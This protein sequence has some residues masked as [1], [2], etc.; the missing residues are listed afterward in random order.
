MKQQDSRYFKAF[1]SGYHNGDLSAAKLKTSIQSFFP[2]LLDVEIPTPKWVGYAFAVVETKE[3]LR[4]FLKLATLKLKDPS[5]TVTLKPFKKGSAL[6]KMKNDIKKRRLVV[7]DLPESWTND[8][9]EEVFSQFGRVEQAHL[10]KSKP[11]QSRRASV[12]FR[13][14]RDAKKVFL[15]TEVEFEGNSAKVEPYEAKPSEKK[16]T[17]GAADAGNGAAGSGRVF[18]GAN[19][20]QAKRKK[21]KRKGKKNSANNKKKAKKTLEEESKKVGGSGQEQ[22]SA[23]DQEAPEQ[24]LPLSDGSQKIQRKMTVTKKSSSYRRKN[25]SNS[26]SLSKKRDNNTVHWVKPTSKTYNYS[27]VSSEVC[28]RVYQQQNYYLRYPAVPQFRRFL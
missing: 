4:S 7:Y 13:N 27:E 19:K 17:N 1:I 26:G 28:Q 24:P 18:G 20:K 15:L 12:V 3:D 2:A 6:K 25:S 11:G 22:G 10:I 8:T 21:N 5:M 14:R 16:V 9:L 23:G